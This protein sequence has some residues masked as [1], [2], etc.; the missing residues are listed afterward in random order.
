MCLMKYEDVVRHLKNEK[1]IPN[2]LIGNGFSI[3]Y[4]PSIF[5]Y[6]AL[7]SFINSS[8]DSELKTLF[9]V[10]NTSNFEQIMRELDLF[11]KILKAFNDSSDIIKKLNA[12]SEKLKKLL[13][14]AV[15]TSHPENVFSISQNKLDSCANFF[16][17]FY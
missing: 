12:I 5:S 13:I 16:E 6:N 15:E 2:L 9:S 11:A 14:E 10:I 17:L 1:R 3:S 4:S 7:S 8:D